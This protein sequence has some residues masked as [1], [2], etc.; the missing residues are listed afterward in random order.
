MPDIIRVGR[1]RPQAIPVGQG[2]LTLPVVRRQYAFG[3]ERM[4]VEPKLHVQVH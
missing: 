2:N 3:E 1:V 4:H